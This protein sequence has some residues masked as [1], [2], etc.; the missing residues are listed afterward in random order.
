MIS[1]EEA[2][3][4]LKDEGCAENV[5]LHCITVADAALEIAQRNIENSRDVDL[6]LVEI[7][8]LLHDLGRAKTHG[9]DHAVVGVELAK[10][11]GVEKPVL[12][13]IKKHI[14]AGITNEEAAY[15]GLPEDDYFPR[16]RE[17]KIVAHADNM[18]KGS[19]VITLKKRKKLLKENGADDEIIERVNTLAREVDPEMKGNK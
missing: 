14:G 16:T 7:G 1:R 15:F 18:V 2:L 6:R 5:I 8:G 19:K 17:E 13:I 4:I 12:E 9:I 3:Q 10:K 11:H